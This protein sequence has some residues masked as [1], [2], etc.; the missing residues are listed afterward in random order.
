MDSNT[1]L[2]LLDVDGVLNPQVSSGTLTLDPARAALVTQLSVLGSIVWATSWSAADTY[3]LANNIGLAG[4][5]AAIAFPSA[6]QT[7][8]VR[9]ETSSTRVRFSHRSTQCSF[10]VGAG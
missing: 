1:A 4:D 5:P 6:I 8:G 9:N 10:G 3:H 7:T 2:I